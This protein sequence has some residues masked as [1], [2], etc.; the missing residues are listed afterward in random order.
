MPVSITPNVANLP[1]ASSRIPRQANSVRPAHPQV[2][3]HQRRLRTATTFFNKTNSGEKVPALDLKICGEDEGCLI[4]HWLDAYKASGNSKRK[5]V[6]GGNWKCNG[7]K[8]SLAQLVSE[9]NAA[10]EADPDFFHKVDVIVAPPMLHLAAVLQ[11]I[12]PSVKVAAQN[13]HFTGNGAYTGEVSAD[14]L[15]DF[16]IDWVIIGHSERRAEPSSGYGVMANESSELIA[17]KTAYAISKG[18]NVIACIG[19]TLEER[20]AGATL[21]VCKQQLAPIVE[22]LSEEDWEKVVLAY[23][24]VWAIGT[25]KSATKEDAQAVHEGIRGYIAAAVSPEVAAAV[26]IQYGGSVKPE[27]CADLGAQ[28]DIDGF[29]VGGASMKGESFKDIVVEPVSLYPDK[30]A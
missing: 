26:R 12:H 1:R 2:C 7:S 21:D 15:V 25:G 24:P 11:S 8:T 18:L 9:I 28:A 22:A 13:C 30:F 17:K 10:A 23:E 27:N 5:L 20:E 6:V 19:E 4:E 16:G 14:Q 29:L 3:R